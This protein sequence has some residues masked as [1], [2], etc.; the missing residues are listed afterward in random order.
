MRQAVGRAML[1]GDGAQLTEMYLE[2]G[3]VMSLQEQYDNGA[4]ELE[5][6]VLLVT[7]GEGPLAEN[8]PP[9]FW[10][11]LADTASLYAH[12]GRHDHAMNLAQG[13]LSHA[14]REPSKLGQARSHFILG[15]LFDTLNQRSAAAKHYQWAHQ[16]FCTLGDRRSQGECLLALAI[17]QPPGLDNPYAREALDLFEQIAWHP[18]IESIQASGL[19]SL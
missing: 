10:R 8:G 15:T 2:L 1:G 6:G 12:Q 9:G 5:E 17:Q 16:E 4:A 19:L 7:G 11:L 13:A 18:G 3:R 14:A